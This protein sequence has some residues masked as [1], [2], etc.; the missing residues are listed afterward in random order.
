MPGHA[1]K[2]SE[3][4]LSPA[5]EGETRPSTLEELDQ[6]SVRGGVDDAEAVE[7]AEDDDEDDED[8]DED[9][10]EDDED[11]EDADDEDEDEDEDDEDDEDEDDDAVE[12]PESR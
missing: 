9:E 4:E 12:D 3:G 10:D 6:P 1:R 8:E 5:V 7:M 11:D 2:R